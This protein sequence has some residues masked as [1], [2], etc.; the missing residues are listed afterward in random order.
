[1][2]SGSN[3]RSKLLGSLEG[4]LQL[5]TYTAVLIGFTGATTT[6][7]WLSNRNQIRNGEAELQANADHLNNNL[8]AHRHLGQ[9]HSARD[10]SPT[11][12][13]EVRQELRDHS[14][15][16]TTLWIELADGR[17]VLPTVGPIAIPQKMMRAT[18]QAHKQDPKTRLISVEDE[19]YLT[20]LGRSYPT[21]ERLWSSA[22]AIDAG[23]IQNEFLGWMILIGVGSMLLSLV[24][25]TVMVRRIVRP[26]LQLSER[27]A[28]LTADTLNQDPIPEMTAAPKE[29]RQLA[30]TY[31]DL[32][33]RL[34]LS[35]NDQRRFVS[36][37]SHELRTP[38]TI[39]Q[40]YLHRTIKRSQGLSDDE[41]RG[42]KTAEEESIRMRM[43][44]DDLLDLSRGDSGQLQ[45]NQEVV[46]LGPLV[47]KVADLSQSNLTDRRLEV[48][49]NIPADE[50]SEALADPGRLQQVLLDLIDNAA[51]YSAEGSLIW[52]L[53]RSHPDGIAIDVKDE[54]I[55]I[56]ESDLPHIFKR[57]HRAKNSSG[58]SGT[59]L[60][61]SVVAL[62]MSAMGGQV[63]VQSKEGEGSCFS[64]ILPKP[65]ST[66]SSAS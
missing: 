41:R 9:G 39:V 16:R 4:Q 12:E 32:M 43:L 42:L 49:N 8:V 44:L 58:S 13:E 62:L 63:C 33:E 19:D 64:V 52:L 17:V 2:A 37:V 61:L 51:K 27:S 56:P 23:R 57:F 25:I 65:A 20:L 50:N 53:L 59:G 18:M 34:A 29:V 54:G 36:A 38:L 30:R 31:S 24:T 14:S 15:V 55:G 28:A 10:W 45:L 66:A 40:G 1:V 35:W 7:L 60:G 3:W 6:G 21:G 47:E 11:I 5:A 48:L 22:K 26:L 46:D